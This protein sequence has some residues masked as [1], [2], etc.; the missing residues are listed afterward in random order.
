MEQGPIIAAT[1]IR[2]STLQAG[3]E[4]TVLDHLRAAMQEGAQ[5]VVFPEWVCLGLVDPSAKS[6]VAAA[7]DGQSRVHDEH[8]RVFSTAARRLGVPVVAGSVPVKKRGKI[9]SVAYVFDAGGNEVLAQM[10]LHPCPKER[11][12][13]IEP[14][15]SVRTL[16]GDGDQG[17][18]LGVLLG[19]DARVP[20]VARAMMLQG[21]NLLVECL[22]TTRPYN[23]V[24]RFNGVHLRAF[25]NETMGVKSCLVGPLGDG[26]MRGNAKVVTVSGLTPHRD[27]VVAEAATTTD[28]ELVIGQPDLG[29][30]NERRRQT[31]LTETLYQGLHA[32]GFPPRPAPPTTRRGTVTLAAAQLELEISTTP[33]HFA[34]R[35]AR[36][37]R[38][39]AQAGAG[40][41]VFPEDVGTCLLGLYLDLKGM[42]ESYAQS[43]RG[44]LDVFK[45]D[46]PPMARLFAGVSPYALE[47]Y[48]NTFGDLAREHGINILAGSI[49]VA[50]GQQVFNVAHLFD[51]RGD[52]VLQ[53]RKVHLFPLEKEWGANEGDGV[54]VADLD[55]GRVGVLLGLDAQSPE[56]GRALAAQ[57]ADLLLA[58]T[59][60]P[61]ECYTLENLS[62]LWARVQDNAV[63][64]VKS[65]LYGQLAKFVVR[66]RSGIY[67]PCAMT[68]DR[69]GILAEAPFTDQ[70]A[71]IT[72]TVDFA[73]LAVHQ[74]QTHSEEPVNWKVLGPALKR[75]GASSTERLRA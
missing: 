45:G 56:L 24:E 68:E 13:G 66:G 2:L 75:H 37:V 11:A 21:A 40:L 32:E 12:L 18:C 38:K 53:Q 43:P 20:E 51:R 14:G 22:M 47:V 55:V 62:G 52:L 3:F 48:R 10:K 34:E 29:R 25:E 8:V 33:K 16:P 73:A 61:D 17:V 5:L 30:L 59:A 46:M 41:V 1:Q 27:G 71:L 65:C 70:D 63:F 28:D 31:R 4:E 69:T 35:M 72:A 19:Q 44:F 49:L 23:S 7:V 26:E 15:T 39:A 74:R 64:G 58:A 6:P 9:Y 50:E 42:V 60:H 57:G 36:Y 54:A 67:A